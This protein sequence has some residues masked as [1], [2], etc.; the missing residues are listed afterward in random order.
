MSKKEEQ[1]KVVWAIWCPKCQAFYRANE[2]QTCPRCGTVN[3]KYM[4]VKVY[5][6]DLKKD[7]DD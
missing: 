6:K 4:A 1:N 2:A 7:E 5:E 3:R